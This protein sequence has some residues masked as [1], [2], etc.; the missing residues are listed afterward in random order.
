LSKWNIAAASH[1]SPYPGVNGEFFHITLNPWTFGGV[2]RSEFGI[3]FDANFATSPGS[4]G[5][6]VFIDSTQ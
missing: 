5:W 6:I 3:H 4:T 1:P 2:T